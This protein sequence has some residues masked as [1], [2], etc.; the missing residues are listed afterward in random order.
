LEYQPG[1]EMMFFFLFPLVILVSLYD[2]R[3]RRIPNWITLPVML[4][5]FYMS[6]PGNP[7]IW[8]ASS[9]VLSAWKTGYMG[10]G[11]SKLWIGLLWCLSSLGNSVVILM[12]SAFMLTG[13]A[14]V[15]VRALSQKRVA[16]GIKTPGAWR[17]VVFMGLL[18]YLN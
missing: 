12:F 10:G 5:G 13:A 16:M 18:A 8:I 9:I 17:A 1:G 4:L 2:L 6:F 3:Y 11:D 7:L 15:V 14:Q